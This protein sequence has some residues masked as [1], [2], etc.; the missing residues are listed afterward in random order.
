MKWQLRDIVIAA[1]LAVVCGA[2]YQ[3]WDLLTT[4]LFA[5]TVSPMVG[6]IVNGLWWIAA[7][8]VPYIIRR[9]GAA[10]FAELVSGFAELLFGSTYGIVGS[11][12]AGLFQGVGPELVF[13]AFGWKKYSWPIMALA[14]VLGGLGASIQWYFQYQGYEFSHLIV[15]GYFVITCVSGALLAGLLPKFIGDGLLRTGALRNFE[16]GRQARAQLNANATGSGSG[17]GR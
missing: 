3:G 13:A 9:P 7:G 4:P 6:A 2:I 5:A 1:L 11:L 8:L 17:D 12:I 16:I 14:G 10:L 15:I